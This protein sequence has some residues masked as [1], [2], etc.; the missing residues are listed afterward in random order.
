MRYKEEVKAKIASISDGEEAYEEQVRRIVTEIYSRALDEAKVTGESVESVTYEILEGIQEALLERHEEI[1]RRV[2]EE[3][4]DIIHAHANDCIELQHKK[5]K[6]AQEAFEE[7]IAREKAHLHESLEAFRAFA[8]EKSLHH[9]AAHLQRVEA[10]IKGIMHQMVQK[11]ASL[12]QD[13][14]M[15]PEKEDLPDQ[16]N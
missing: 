1:L 3:M 2:S 16:D 9:F 11:I 7:T 15:Q 5:A 13:K 8:K 12:T 6:A 14:R 10:H 4:V